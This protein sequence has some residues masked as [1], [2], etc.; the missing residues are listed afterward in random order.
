MQLAIFKKMEIT[1][2]FPLHAIYEISAQNLAYIHDASN[3]FKFIH[4]DV[5]VTIFVFFTS[6]SLSLCVTGTHLSLFFSLSLSL[7]M[8]DQS[9]CHNTS[10]GCA[11]A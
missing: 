5:I 6:L 8:W 3:I 7:I 11:L 1:K 9:Q 2:N 4:S 10:C